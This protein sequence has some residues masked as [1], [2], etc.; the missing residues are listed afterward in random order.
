MSGVLEELYYGNLEATPT[1]YKKDS[2][3]YKVTC[4]MVEIEEKLMNLLKGE[5]KDCFEKYTMISMKQSD[6][7]NADSFVNGF[8]LGAKFM[9]EV[10]HK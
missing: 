4:E 7:T 2:E 5:V 9:D 10:F 6:L 1:E 8:R 3:L